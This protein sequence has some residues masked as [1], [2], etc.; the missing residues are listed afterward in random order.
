MMSDLRPVLMGGEPFGEL[1]L[2][3]DGCGLQ[4]GRRVPVVEVA[5]HVAGR[6]SR[7]HLEQGG[8]EG[9]ININKYGK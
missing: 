5:A 4:R 8:A 9:K 3:D 6:E 1:A 2:V 7:H